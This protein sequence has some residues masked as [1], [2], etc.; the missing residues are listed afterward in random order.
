MLQNISPPAS[1]PAPA[2]QAE[3]LRYN[4]FVSIQ[5]CQN[6]PARKHGTSDPFVKFTVGGKMVHR[7]KTMKSELNPVWDEVFVAVVSELGSPLEVKVYSQNLVKDDLLGQHSLDLQ[8]LPQNTTLETS[9][10]LH[11]LPDSHLVLSLNLVCLPASDSL[12]PHHQHSLLLPPSP[13]GRRKASEEANSGVLSLGLVEG[14]HLGEHKLP[15]QELYCKFRYLSRYSQA[16]LSL[17][18]LLYYYSL[19][20]SLWHE[21]CFVPYMPE[22]PFTSDHHINLDLDRRV[23]GVK[24]SSG[25]PVQSGWSSWSS[26]FRMLEP[27]LTW[28]SN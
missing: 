2:E 11:P 9:L 7:T 15:D 18:Q 14:R 1:P 8:S 17:V 23:V 27:S 3:S 12:Q 22:G 4:L 28:R 19:I 21:G 24:S 13:A 5:S 16:V 25:R 6:L 20:G 26:T 10:P